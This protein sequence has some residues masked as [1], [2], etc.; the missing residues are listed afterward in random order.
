MKCPPLAAQAEFMLAFHARIS[1]MAHAQCIW[2]D[3]HAFTC[4]YES[5]S[6]LLAWHCIP[7]TFRRIP[8][9]P[10]IDFV[11]HVFNPEIL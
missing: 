5:Q 2:T 3:V 7:S 4:K 9:T 11:R 6:R 1:C 8:E 10:E